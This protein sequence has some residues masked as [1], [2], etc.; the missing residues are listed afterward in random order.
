MKYTFLLLSLAITVNLSAIEPLKSSIDFKSVIIEG[1]VIDENT[2]EG[3]A[4]AEVKLLG[5]E[6]LIYTDFDGNFSFTDVAPGNYSISVDYISYKKRIITKIE[7]EIGCL[8]VTIKLKPVEKLIPL[9]S[10]PH[11][12]TA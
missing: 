7:P 5:S 3:L 1:R 9:N 8:P 11:F 6:K 2:G 4:G 10:N 12:P